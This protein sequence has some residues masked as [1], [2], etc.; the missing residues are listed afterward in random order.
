MDNH[1]SSALFN[2][3]LILFHSFNHISTILILKFLNVGMH[4]KIKPSVFS[5]I[6]PLTDNT[7]IQR[8]GIIHFVQ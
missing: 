4:W 7:I 3:H 5:E 1:E 8:H 6:L 2:N